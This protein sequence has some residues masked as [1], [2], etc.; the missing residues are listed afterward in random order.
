M[1]K[2]VRAV[3]V[4]DDALLV[5]HRNKFGEEYYTLIGGG[6]SAGETPEQALVREVHE[7]SSL[8]VA[9]PRLVYVEQAGDP[10]GYQF[11]FLCDYVSGKVALQTA[12]IEAKIHALGT[13]LY[14][15]AWL[16]IKKLA[17]VSFVSEVLK[18]TLIKAFT[19]GF[20]SQP[21]TI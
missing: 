20:P 21:Q 1:R 6:I 13:N 3:V 16:P 7:E 5:M 9:N 15:P 18:H 2:A 8:S 19:Q 14:E 11:I 10:Y 4:K 12:S 17:E